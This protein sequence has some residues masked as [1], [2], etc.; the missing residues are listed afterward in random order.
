MAEKSVA[1]RIGVTGKDDVKSSLAE[2]GK[3]GQDAGAQIAQ[4]MAAA[5]T[6]TDAQAA[7]YK[8][9][10]AAA[11]E[12]EIANANQQA[13][14]AV[15]GVGAAGGLSAEAAFG[16][17]Q[18]AARGSKDLESALFGVQ[19]QSK[20]T[21]SEIMALR[22]GVASF[23][24]A[25]GVGEVLHFA[26][27][28]LDAAAALKDQ[29]QEVG[30]TVEQY[31]GY[32][33]VLQEGGVEQDQAVT[34]LRRF[35]QELGQAKAA[36]GPARDA[37]AQ[38]GV[39]LED[40]ADTALPKVAQGLLAI[41]DSSERARLEVVLFGRAGQELESA[42]S[43]LAQGSADAVEQLRQMGQLR[44]DE[45][46]GRAKAAVKDLDDALTHLEVSATPAVVSLA[47]ALANVL[48]YLNRLD[49]SGLAN[50]FANPAGAIADYITGAGT[51]AS[52]T[53]AQASGI[54]LPLY[55]GPIVGGL[56]HSENETLAA[57]SR[58]K[59]A[60]ANAAASGNSSGGD[61]VQ[62]A[63]EEGTRLVQQLDAQTEAQNA[64]TEAVEAGTL[65]QKQANEQ[66]QEAARLAPL[67]AAYD[68]AAGA[69]KNALKQIIDELTN[70]YAANAAARTRALAAAQLADSERA[71][72]LARAELAL[73]SESDD[74]RAVEMAEL[75]EINRLKQEGIGVDTAEGRA[76]V[77]NA[78][79]LAA[80]KLQFDRVAQSRQEMEGL[81]ETIAGDFSNFIVQSDHGWQAFRQMGLSVLQAIESEIL[82]LAAINPLENLLFGTSLPTMS[83]LGGLF[84]SL[85]GGGMSTVAVTPSVFG[86]YHEGGM[87]GAPSGFRA[88]DPQIF[89]A[90]PRLHAGGWLMDDEVPAI[91]KRGERVLNP[92]ETAA[93][94]ARSAPP[95]QICITVDVSGARG[96]AE[97]EEAAQRGA[98]KAIQ[99]SAMMIQRYDANLNRRI[100]PVI[101]AAQHDPRFRA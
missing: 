10:A 78:G 28:I 32:L 11:K 37:L 34:A 74:R 101:H 23:I 25:L 97:I 81:F 66:V 79:T 8:A 88:A 96:S 99:T 95:A 21:F 90:A 87:V 27:S 60:Q 45:D 86:T 61:P 40:S 55:T 54:D 47:G 49:R 63:I 20:G 48:D 19:E 50:F 26:G 77:A 82:K 71:I 64:A 85:F 14:N 91:L 5:G 12:A 98:E 2:I 70:A 73:A 38:F 29:A 76:L 65:S 83:G 92:A 62:R 93:Y 56:G 3:A 75:T 36:S 72:D 43:G 6:A 80:L 18:N 58:A 7:K 13:F 67:E 69:Q 1:I 53:A 44:T 9:L 31:Q 30:L 52:R 51:S 89:A 41:Q 84:G 4:G 57:L 94:N 100:L 46:V 15:L 35:N 22:G 33:H 42:L 68:K 24:A 59:D 39:T 16:V 17:F